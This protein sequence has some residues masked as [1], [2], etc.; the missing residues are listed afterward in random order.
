V[1]FFY[2]HNAA[3]QEKRKTIGDDS[4]Y[5]YRC[6]RAL[7]ALLPSAHSTP[8]ARAEQA[9][10]FASSFERRHCLLHATAEMSN[11]RME[12]G[13]EGEGQKFSENCNIW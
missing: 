12:R 9:P 10:S 1:V 13:E 3:L 2:G 8:D 5:F 11:R 7:L 4:R 6:A